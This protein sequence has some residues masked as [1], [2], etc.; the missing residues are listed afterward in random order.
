MATPAEA[1]RL[2]LGGRLDRIAA[3]TE[4]L[5]A[6]DS[7]TDDAAGVRRVQELLARE[8][9]SAG[10][11]VAWAPVGDRGHAV[12]DGVLELGDG[13]TVLV[14]G[15]ADTVWPVGTAADRP[16]ERSDGTW[17]G[18]G[19]GDMKS[20]LAVAV[21]ACAVH[22]ASAARGSVRLLVI[23]D[24]E[25]GSVASRAAIEAA[26]RAADACLTLEAA[27]P[28]GGLVTSRGAVGAMEVR[29]RGRAAH[30][31]DPGPH[32]D[33][34]APLV[35]IAAGIGRLRVPDASASVGV[36]RAGTAR[37]IVPEEGEAH[38]D[39]RASSTEA[40]EALAEEIRRVVA[41]ERASGADVEVRGGVTRPAFPRSPGT[42][43]LYEAAAA[44]A[45]ALGWPVH[46]VA[47]RGGSDASFAA[48]LG[49]PTLDGL[50]PV[51]HG[52]CSRD[53]RVDEDSIAVFGAVLAALI[54]H[55]LEG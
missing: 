5:V 46:E 39:L 54:G 20:C 24:E 17:R 7:P 4:A 15:H 9:Q 10:F 33:A 55:V 30:V 32:A 47:E 8:L 31:T 11:R 16:F 19:V 12:L 38:V 3:L 23:P 21:H 34:L 29:S 6:V 22:A 49:V 18:P 41:A 36:L 1:L 27:R 26:S 28:G 50:G 14:L 51:C 45:G 52:S 42:L 25:A 48:S 53:E 2:E 44:T 40:C 35:A 13:P 37:Q 43:A